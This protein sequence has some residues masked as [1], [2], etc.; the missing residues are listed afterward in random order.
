MIKI[1]YSAEILI[2]LAITLLTF[3]YMLNAPLMVLFGADV[4]FSN[5]VLRILT[6]MFFIAALAIR[7]QACKKF[8]A[9]EL[10]VLTYLLLLGLRVT[11]DTLLFDVVPPLQTGSR[12]LLFYFLL[13]ILP[14][15]IIFLV[16]TPAYAETLTILMYWTLV[17]SNIAIIVLA[18]KAPG[19]SLENSLGGA[20]SS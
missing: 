5:I 6:I 12:V 10:L 13:T 14:V 18:I 11:V 8:G 4:A 17:F 19:F 16:F 7:F 3:G 2:S 1:S 9:F 15:A 20:I